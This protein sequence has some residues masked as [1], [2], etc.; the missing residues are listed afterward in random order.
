MSPKQLLNVTQGNDPKY[1]P[2]ARKVFFDR[3]A[4]SGTPSVMDWPP[5]SLELNIFKAGWDHLDTMEPKAANIERRALNVVQEAWR[6]LHET[7]NKT[8]SS[9]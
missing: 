4:H 1:T 6:T 9:S 5:Q 2:I 3:K 8:F 7:T